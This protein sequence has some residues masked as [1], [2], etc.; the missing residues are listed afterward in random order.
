MSTSVFWPAAPDLQRAEI[1][2]HF[3]GYDYVGQLVAPPA[4]AGPRPLVMVIHNYQG[5]KFFDVDVAEYMARLGYV[6]VAVDLYGG[7]VPDELRLCPAEPEALKAHLHSC[8]SAMVDLDHDPEH[9]RALMQAWLAHCLAQPTVDESVSAA[10]MGYCFGGMAVIEAVRGGLDLG[11]VV[12]L[13]GLLQTGEDPNAAK[14]G[15]VRPALKPCDNSY[16][17]RTVLV[18]ENGADD[19][20]VTEQSKQ[21]FFAEMDAAGVDWVFHQYAG[22]PHGF[23]LPPSLGGPGHLHEA[24]D[25]RSTVSMLNLFREIFP[26]VPQNHVSHNAAGTAIPA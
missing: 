8:F 7:R 5:L 15:A 19:H 3:R 24:A 25:R 1:A 10:A 21:R 22:T 17:T 26:G 13:H 9:F 20:L 23:A 12:S 2:F 4:A 11:G 14:F 6:G 18:V 16:N